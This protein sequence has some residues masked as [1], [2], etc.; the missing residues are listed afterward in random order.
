[1]VSLTVSPDG[2]VLVVADQAS[3]GG[4]WYAEDNEEPTPSNGG[5]RDASRTP[6]ISYTGSSGLVAGSCWAAE[7]PSSHTWEPTYPS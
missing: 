5:L 7:V 3:D 4:C 6:G 1:M 2:E